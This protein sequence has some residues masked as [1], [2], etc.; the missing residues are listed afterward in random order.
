MWVV[1]WGVL[2]KAHLAVPQWVWMFWSSSWN[3]NPILVPPDDF[4]FDFCLFGFLLITPMQDWT[5]LVFHLIW[6]YFNPI[7]NYNFKKRHGSGSG[8][9]SKQDV[10]VPGHHCQQM[11]LIN[12]VTQQY[13][14]ATYNTPQNKSRWGF[15][16]SD[17]S[18]SCSLCFQPPGPISLK[19]CT[20]LFS[21]MEGRL[22]NFQIF[23]SNSCKYMK[24]GAL[25]DRA[26]SR[27]G[28]PWMLCRGIAGPTRSEICTLVGIEPL[29]FKYFLHA[30]WN[31][32]RVECTIPLES[33]SRMQGFFYAQR[34]TLTLGG[35]DAI[36]LH[37]LLFLTQ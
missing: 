31:C 30:E 29:V 14:N 6:I 24:S 26:S 25:G 19:F 1:F 5:Y 17:C 27:V 22:K 15:A 12:Y 3:V 23:S 9:R 33:R 8:V 7:L 35:S 16:I 37:S 10:L 32:R 4:I 18:F 28:R 21:Q 20:R 34:A 11:S 36:P 2:N 13:T